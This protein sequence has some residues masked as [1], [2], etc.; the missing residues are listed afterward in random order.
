MHRLGLTRS[1]SVQVFNIALIEVMEAANSAKNLRNLQ[2]GF[3]PTAVS[4]QKKAFRFGVKLEE[5]S[6][7]VLFGN[8]TRPLL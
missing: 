5:V 1:I 7:K 2:R 8:S 6:P 3:F 4:L